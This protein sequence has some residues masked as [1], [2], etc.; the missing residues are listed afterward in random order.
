M[1][2]EVGRVLTVPN[3]PMD[4]S[5]EIPEDVQKDPMFQRVATALKKPENMMT[6]IVLLGSM[7]QDRR[8]GQSKLDAFAERGLGTL[9]FRGEMGRLNQADKD[10]AEKQ[11]ADIEYKQGQIGVAREQVGATRERTAAESETQRMM[12]GLQAGVAGMNDATERWRTE[13]EGAIDM[14][15]ARIAAGAK[16]SEQNQLLTSDDFKIA[17]SVYDSSLN[18]DKPISF[19][20]ALGQVLR[21]KILTRPEFAGYL[22]LFE[23]EA[24]P[25]P[26]PA[27][28]KP[29]KAPT[30]KTKP[31]YTS[32][33]M[34]IPAMG[35]P[36][37]RLGQS[38]G[39]GSHEAPPAARRPEFLWPGTK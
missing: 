37:Y 6:A 29:T 7:M 21:I 18:S 10:E 9:A 20:E 19:Q 14:E 38:M 39:T 17:Q 22:S 11:K 33:P 12:A 5:K 1:A 15:L 31:T 28:G 34:P 30:K 25:T 8:P 36:D 16:T 3:S 13:R 32:R 23:K 2:N 35:L 4:P 27:S 26:T 24:A